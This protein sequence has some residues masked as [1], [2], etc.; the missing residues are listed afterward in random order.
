MSVSIVICPTDFSLASFMSKSKTAIGSL[1]QAPTK[2][3]V[4]AFAELIKEKIKVKNK[5]FMFTPE[6]NASEPY[7][8]LI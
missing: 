8:I 1:L 6:I 7:S 2:E 4:P 3:M 5:N